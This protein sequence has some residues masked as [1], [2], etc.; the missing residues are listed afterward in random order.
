LEKETGNR[1]FLHNLEIIQ[2]SNAHRDDMGKPKYTGRVFGFVC[3]QKCVR[4][5]GNK[6]KH[7]NCNELIKASPFAFAS[8][9]RTT[10]FQKQFTFQPI[11]VACEVAEG[12]EA[13]RR[14]R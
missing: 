4:T 3:S 12:D 11:T 6:N 2:I 7:L 1:P 14:R 8:L 10:V 9:K 5:T 13:K